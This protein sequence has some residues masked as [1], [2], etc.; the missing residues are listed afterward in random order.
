MSDEL[1][2]GKLIVPEHSPFQWVEWE[3]GN[4]LTDGFNADRIF[5]QARQLKNPMAVSKLHREFA[6]LELI[7]EAIQ[8]F[9]NKWGNLGGERAKRIPSGSVEVVGVEWSSWVSQVHQARLALR[10]E[11]Q[12][13]TKF[14]NLQL[15]QHTAGA[16]LSNDSDTP[17]VHLVPKNLQGAIWLQIAQ[18]LSG[19]TEH[20]KCQAPT[21]VKWFAIDP[22]KPGRKPI[23][24]SK[25]CAKR[26]ERAK[27]GK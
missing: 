8:D 7:P 24:C 23:Y 3:G 19:F 4:Y 11:L 6:D 5:D 13:A 20:N 2:V 17:K 27:K 18:E 22:S 14:I 12:D 10:G 25:R 15:R 9:A 1:I 26:A 16:Y 21:C